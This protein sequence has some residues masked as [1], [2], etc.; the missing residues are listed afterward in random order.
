MAVIVAAVS[1]VRV[2]RFALQPRW[3]AWHLLLLVVLVSFTWL[4]RWQLDAFEHKADHG[5]AAGDRRTVALDALSR[6]GGRLTEGDVGRPVAATGSYDPH[7][8]RLVDGRDRPG[9]GGT[10]FWVVSMLRTA[11]GVQPVVRGWVR[12]RDDPEATTPTGQVT[13]TGLLQRSENRPTGPEAAD[14]G[15]D[16]LPYVATVTVLDALPYP[17]GEL[18]DGYLALRSEQ[19][20]TGSARPVP[21]EG[22]AAGTGGV[23]RWRNLAYALQWWLFAAAAVF[24]WWMV[25]RRAALEQQEHEPAPDEGPPPLVAPRR[26][27]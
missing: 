25:L 11:S 18:Y 8:T 16:Q 23:G 7:G 2:T 13:V 10:G 4:G 6:P 5:V 1:V 17:P 21:V 22:Q 3:L 14:V 19:P 9:G 12:E 24:F 20:S 27:T 26:T 15:P